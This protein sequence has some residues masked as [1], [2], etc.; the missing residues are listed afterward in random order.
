L[1][2]ITSAFAGIIKGNP[3]ILGVVLAGA[4]PTFYA[5]ILLCALA[6]PSCTPNLKSLNSAVGKIIKGTPRFLGAP[7]AHGHAHFHFRH[8]FIMG[9][10]IRKVLT[11][12][13]FARFICYRNVTNF[14]KKL[15][16]A[17]TATTEK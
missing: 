16:S 3:N 1:I 5:M 8:D 2:S 13:E 7:L 15:G 4:T 9:L 12:F 6:N 17:T 11:K 10:C 14:I